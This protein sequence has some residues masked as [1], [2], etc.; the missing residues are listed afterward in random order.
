MRIHGGLAGNRPQD[1]DE[2]GTPGQVEVPAGQ[3]QKSGGTKLGTVTHAHA[4]GVDAVD[5]EGGL[6]GLLL[7]PRHDKDGGVEDDH[8]DEGE[9][10]VQDG[11]VGDEPQG[12]EL[13]RTTHGETLVRV[14]VRF[15]LHGEHEDEG[16]GH[17]V[18]PAHAD[19][20]KSALLGH[21][22]NIPQGCGDQ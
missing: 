4:L 2:P 13:L 1:G 22:G 5:A 21:Q 12:E 8:D 20:D 9:Q 16:H 10:K 14:Q 11:E 19:E 3:G 7:A 15:R 17:G 6:D 18:A